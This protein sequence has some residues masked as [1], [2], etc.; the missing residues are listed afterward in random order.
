MDDASE[1]PM[2]EAPT[3]EPEAAPEQAAPEQKITDGHENL[4]EQIHALRTSMSRLEHQLSWA[5]SIFKRQGFH[6]PEST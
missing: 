2:T 4:A 3:P 5:I 1:I 6:P